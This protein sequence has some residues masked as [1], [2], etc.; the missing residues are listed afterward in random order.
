MI[1]VIILLI[2]VNYVY[3]N[4]FLQ[5]FSPNFQQPN[6]F[7]NI[8]QSNQFKDDLKNLAKSE[9]KLSDRFLTQSENLF[10]GL[11]STSDQTNYF[12]SNLNN[13]INTYQE[14]PNEYKNQLEL[15][16]QSLVDASQQKRPEPFSQPQFNLP[17]ESKQQFNLSPDQL[18]QYFSS[19][20]FINDL[21]N[22]NDQNLKNRIV[23]LVQGFMTAPNK[24]AYV[25]ANRV[26]IL[27]LYQQL[28]KQIKDRIN[29]NS[30][31]ASLISP[32]NFMFP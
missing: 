32:M 13:L 11:M 6:Q 4:P 16:F 28:P 14:L 26:E 10:K 30:L 19:E 24:Q 15:L 18:S 7:S 22:I 17:V 23:S 27:Q 12:Q 5:Q 25:A 2:G 31:F 1:R 8:L 21:N 20:S 9:F 3:G 29:I